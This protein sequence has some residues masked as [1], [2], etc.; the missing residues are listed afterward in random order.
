M[1]DYAAMSQAMVTAAESLKN[2]L[3]NYKL[4]NKT[5]WLGQGQAGWSFYW[6]PHRTVGFD[7][8]KQGSPDLCASA[9]TTSPGSLSREGFWSCHT[10][11]GIKEALLFPF[12]RKTACTIQL[13]LGPFTCHTYSD[14][15]PPILRLHQKDPW[16]SLLNAVL[17]A[18][19]NGYLF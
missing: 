3:G 12:F 17:F 14:T 2:C 6:Y 16:L 15:G 9:P 7:L 1:L 11:H 10:Y 18:K 13:P 19:E 8:R 5:S 4:A